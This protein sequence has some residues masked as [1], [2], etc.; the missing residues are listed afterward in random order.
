MHSVEDIWN[1][2]LAAL[3]NELSETTIAAWFDET[4]PVDVEEGTL[5]L[6]C[7]N[8]FKRGYIE[9]LFMDNIRAALKE[10]F[11]RD[12]DVRVLNT[13]QYQSRGLKNVK[14]GFVDFSVDFCIC[15][16]ASSIMSYIHISLRNQSKGSPPS[17]QSR[18]F[19][20][21]VVVLFR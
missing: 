12:I 8:E 11:S 9:Q 7:P 21:I 17:S 10:L 6:F 19:G 4:E 1:N 2:I 13:E 14:N 18:L 5:L 20:K 15:F 16:D 3:H